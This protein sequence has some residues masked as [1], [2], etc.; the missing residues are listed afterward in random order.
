MQHIW[1]P[2][3]QV[4]W[5]DEGVLHIELYTYVYMQCL[6]DATAV[7]RSDLREEA[8]PINFCNCSG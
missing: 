5:I 8:S 1:A 2:F 7:Y 4:Q 6:F 3:A